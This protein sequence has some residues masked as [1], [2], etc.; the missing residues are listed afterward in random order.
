M[1][2]YNTNTRREYNIKINYYKVKKELKHL[3]RTQE[4]LEKN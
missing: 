3:R 1:N 4:T 2:K